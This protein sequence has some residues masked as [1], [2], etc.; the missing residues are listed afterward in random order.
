MTG[1]G[2]VVWLGAGADGADPQ[3]PYGLGDVVFT[4]GGTGWAG[5]TGAGTVVG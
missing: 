3:R 2:T 5:A 4:S 1:A